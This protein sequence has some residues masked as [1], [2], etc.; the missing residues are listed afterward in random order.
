MS[1][2]QLKNKPLYNLRIT[3]PVEAMKVIKQEIDPL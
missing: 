1:I 2:R 3:S